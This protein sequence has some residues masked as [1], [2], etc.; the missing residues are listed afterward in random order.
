MTIPAISNLINGQPRPANKTWT[1]NGWTM[2]VTEPQDTELAIKSV[3]KPRMRNL[4]EVVATLQTIGKENRWIDEDQMRHITTTIGSPMAFTRQCVSRVNTF[5]ITLPTYIKSL[6]GIDPNGFFYQGLST[7][8]GGLPTTV[9]IAG[10]EVVLA[11]WVFAH[12]ALANAPAVIKVSA[13]EP[14]TATLFAH[15]MIEKGLTPPQLLHF[16]ME[17]ERDVAQIRDAVSKTRQSVIFGG[18]DGNR[19][20]FGPMPM[21]PAHKAMPYFSQR[22]P[23]VVLSD[24][25]WELSIREIIMGAVD[26]RGNNCLS[27]KKLYVPKAFGQPFLDALIAEADRLRRGDVLDEKTNVGTVDD[28]ARRRAEGAIGDGT[29]IYDKGMFIVV[30]NNDRSNYFTTQIPYAAL[31][32]RFYDEKEDPIALANASVENSTM[33][34]RSIVAAIYTADADRYRALA[35]QLK[36]HKVLHNTRTT[37][38]DLSSLHHGRHLFVEL[39]RSAH[40]ERL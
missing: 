39:M 20:V 5:L 26:D 16:D 21:M 27:T 33:E 14:L 2:P 22:C 4:N 29:V 11:P 19:K 3:Q 8:N 15:A 24:A 18:E 13:A 37:H 40:V 30:T 32:V 28:T 7:F 6:G 35:P 36:S 9:A 10:D 25:N 23:A 34:A 1:S 31:G 12:L 38:W 17:Q